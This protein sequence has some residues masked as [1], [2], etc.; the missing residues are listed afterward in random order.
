M[1]DGGM[2]GRTLAHDTITG[3]LGHGGMGEVVY[4]AR[5]TRTLVSQRGSMA[6]SP[7]GRTTGSG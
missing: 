3:L 7:L 2:I 1:S 5:D 6:D 4:Q